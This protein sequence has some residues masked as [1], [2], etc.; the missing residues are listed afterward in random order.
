M[1]AL[2]GLVVLAWCA[3]LTG[4][5]AGPGPAA[6]AE[7][8]ESVDPRAV[9]IFSG[10]DGSAKPWSVLIDSASRADAVILGET[11]GHSVGLA[12]AAALWEDIIAA[13]PSAALSLEFFERDTQAA[14]D[15][16]RLNLIDEEA[17]RRVTRRS[18][19]NYPEGHRAMVEAARSAGL[20]V[21]ASNAPR[22]YVRLARTKGFE[23]LAGLTAEQKRLFLLPATLPEGRYRDDF[24]RLM[25]E[26]PS[27]AHGES[28]ASGRRQA[29]EA[30][31]RSQSL[32]DWTMA[33]SIA[34]ALEAGHRPVVHVVGRFHSDFE[35]GL[36]QALRAIRPGVTVVTLSV[37]P[38]SAAALR[39][40]DLGRADFVIHAGHD[41]R[42]AR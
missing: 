30:M 42:R 13:A 22:P 11:H 1:R 9:L 7:S 27:M 40:E 26:D 4:C 15:D 8:T 39:D 2:F 16:Y 31:F 38:V 34:R 18:A 25:T 21:I 20:P 3:G 23:A 12:A 33:E 32:W 41:A 28:D 5:S 14:L 6:S 24:I 17:F 36:V 10:H 37:L 19:G 29:A 35:G